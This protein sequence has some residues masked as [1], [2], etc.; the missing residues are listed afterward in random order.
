M[1]N[2]GKHRKLP[3]PVGHADCGVPQATA[4]PQG[5][6]YGHEHGQRNSERTAGIRTEK[7]AV[8]QKNAEKAC[9]C[10][11]ARPPRND[12]NEAFSII[13]KDFFVDEKECICYNQIGRK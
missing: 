9:F 13:R 10:V 1:A 5:G 8:R 6:C 4:A 7:F 2:Y 12:T 3:H 11:I